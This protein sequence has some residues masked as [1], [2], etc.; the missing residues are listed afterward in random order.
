[1]NSFYGCT[2]KEKEAHVKKVFSQPQ[3]PLLRPPF[4]S[5]WSS[6]AG[7][8]PSKTNCGRINDSASSITSIL[9]MLCD[10]ALP[11]TLLCSYLK[12]NLKMSFFHFILEWQILCFNSSLLDSTDMPLCNL[13]HSDLSQ[14]DSRTHMHVFDRINCSASCS[15]DLQPLLCWSYSSD[16]TKPKNPKWIR[17]WKPETPT[18]QPDMIF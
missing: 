5:V 13:K 17:I 18:P 7:L 11:T 8:A 6:K 14:Q 4:I 15:T 9:V 10:F 3:Q 12:L 1:M 2:G 16:K